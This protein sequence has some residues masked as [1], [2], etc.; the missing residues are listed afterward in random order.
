MTF[1]HGQ[2]VFD[3]NSPTSMRLQE[4]TIEE[5]TKSTWLLTTVIGLLTLGIAIAL[6]LLTK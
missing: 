2:K 4:I 5:P 3:A 6:W 1:L